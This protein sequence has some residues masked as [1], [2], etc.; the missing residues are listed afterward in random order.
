MSEIM[1]LLPN[2]TRA[3]ILGQARVRKLKSFFYLNHLYSQDED[4]YLKEH[5]LEE[6]N[7]ELGN[8]LNRSPKGVEQRLRILNLHR[9]LEICNYQNL[10]C[11]IRQRLVTWRDSIRQ[12]NNYTCEI[13]GERSN[14]VI[15][16]IRGFNLLFDEVVEILDFPIYDNIF[17]Y[18]QNQL[19]EFLETF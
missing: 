3:S 6:N 4:E 8:K 5:Y 12:K 1:E 18:T 9:P 16:H 17:L 7:Q 14:I 15:H 13:T 19:D 11:Y 10:Q 2:R